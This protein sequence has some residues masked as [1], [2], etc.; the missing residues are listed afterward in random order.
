MIILRQREF[1]NKAN[2]EAQRKWMLEKAKEMGFEIEPTN[3]FT[4]GKVITKEGTRK[5]TAEE[6]AKKNRE[7][8]KETQDEALKGFR[9]G[10]NRTGINL[11]S[12]YAND[13]GGIDK[14]AAKQELKSGKYTISRDA[15]TG[16]PDSIGLYN[17]PVK[18]LDF[19]DHSKEGFRSQRQE[20]LR[21]YRESKKRKESQNSQPK[22]LKGKGYAKKIWNGEV[23]LGKAGNRAAL[24]GAGALA[25]GA[26]AYGIHKLRKNRREKKAEE[27]ER[28]R[29][30]AYEE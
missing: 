29:V 12:A 5:L 19:I 2:K 27:E 1:G 25:T 11:V 17:T 26:T 10:N 22:S 9:K 7:L 4:S 13:I 20:E 18:D 23:G 14:L 6:L 21:K 16:K 28:R 24:I 30:A 8:R 3:Y 15:E